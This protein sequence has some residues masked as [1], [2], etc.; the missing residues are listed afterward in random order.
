LLISIDFNRQCWF[1]IQC[2]NAMIAALSMLHLRLFYQNTSKMTISYN[3]LKAY[4]PLDLPAEKVGEILTDTGLEVEGIEK[5]ESVKGG[6]KGVVIGEVLTCVQHPN[7]DRLK[8]TT[9]NIG[10]AEPLQIVCGA[11]NV[12]AGQKV[13]VATVG[14]TLYADDKPFEIK[15]GKI[16][17]EESNGMICAE[18]ELGLGKGHD[19]IMILRADAKVGSAA[20]DYFEIETDYIFEIGLTPNRTDAMCHFGVARDLKAGLAQQGIETKLTLPMVSFKVDDASRTI[21]VNVTNKEACPQ[22]LGITISDVKVG[23]SPNWVKNRLAAIG[24]KPINNVVDITN[25][26]LH[27]LG[28]PLHAFDADK[29]AGGEVII[30]NLE[31]DTT[32]KTLDDVERKL[33]QDDLMICDANGGMCLAGVFG[34]NHSGVTAYSKNVFLEAAWFNPVTI[35]KAAKRHALNTDASFRFERGVDPNMTRFALM[36]A[37]MLIK[38]IAGGKISSEI[39]EAISQEF[40]AQKVLINLTRVNELIGNTISAE[41]VEEILGLL[42]IDIAKKDDEN[43]HLSVPTY[44]ADVTREA[45]VIEEILRIYGFNNIELPPRM[46]IS[47]SDHDAVSPSKIRKEI[48]LALTANGY[49]EIMNNSL[50]KESY[51]Q[52][53]NAEDSDRLVR[54]LNPLSQDLGVMRQNLLYGGLEVVL[55]NINRQTRNVK[56]FEFGKSYFKE[57]DGSYQEEEKLMML[58][59]GKATTEGWNSKTEDASF[60]D[61]KGVASLVLARI[62][63]TG[64]QES[65]VENNM[66]SEALS[67]ARGGKEFALIGKVNQEIVNHFEIDQPVF[68]AIFNWESL[69]KSIGSSKIKFQ[70]LPRYPWVR[71]DLALL[72]DEDTAYESLKI[73]SKKAG[74][75]L[76]QEVN[77]FD[78]FEGKNLPAGKKSY[79]MSF[80]FQDAEETLTDKRVEAVM[81]KIISTLKKQHN[82]DLR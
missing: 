79:A 52:K 31:A 68:A 11:P 15:N 12:A 20:S 2:K 9:V 39:Q 44:R 30:Q 47:I 8:I 59:S 76:L 6:L 55:R 17:G 53:F 14:T 82:A 75:K 54:I 62:G 33:H 71:R 66:F 24:L 10:D 50:T 48:S 80:V 41:K 38:E 46:Q 43:W 23:P 28:H 4:L 5:I 74:G 69:L 51:Y 40:P 29:I 27:E 32:F 37:A 81:D 72:V 49:S 3:W 21:P 36:R 63:T 22:Y 61:L 45:D 73:A 7:A 13:P 58:L 26:V 19:G 77:L 35:R 16:R 57:S 70:N 78:V 56:V 65:S 34:G 60:Y 67:F 42:E 25:F 1:L 18:D 64:L